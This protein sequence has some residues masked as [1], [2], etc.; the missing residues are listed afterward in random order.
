MH[1]I[2]VKHPK[3]VHFLL[4]KTSI[5]ET[6]P[7]PDWKG[8]I[9]QRIRWA[10]KADKFEDKRIF[11]VLVFIYLFNLS[12][13]VLP[14]LAFWQPQ[15][16]FY[17]LIMLV[18]KTII[19]LRFMVPVATFFNEQKLLVWFPLMQPFHIVYTVIAGWLGKFGKYTW[20]GRTVK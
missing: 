7:M 17:W 2:F 11:W 18:G 4:A 20:K 19:D 9:N 5:V 6:L 16:L 10:S 3:Q 14:A 1:K 8:F 13:V 12:F 15:I